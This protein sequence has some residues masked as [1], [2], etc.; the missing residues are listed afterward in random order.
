MAAR[1]A[2]SGFARMAGSVLVIGLATIIA[3][4]AMQHI[5]GLIPCDL[6]LKQR[7]PYYAALPLTAFAL[8]LHRLS[9]IAARGL[10]APVGMIFLAGALL[11]FYHAGVEYGFWP[12]PLLARKGRNK[13]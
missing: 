4:L 12:G 6:C 11:A 8:L 9:P 7:W 10:M 1:A 3:A 2:I 13:V 5:A